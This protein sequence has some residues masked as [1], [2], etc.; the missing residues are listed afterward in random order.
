MLKTRR[1]VAAV[2]SVFV[3]TSPGW[4][5]IR[6]EVVVSGLS[7]PVAFIQDPAQSNVQFIVEQAG[8]IRVV[9]DGELLARDFLDLQ[10]QTT[11]SGEQGLLGLAFP[12]D[13]AVSRRFY[14][15]FTNTAGHTVVAR[16]LRSA[17]DPLVADPS[18]RF[19]LLWPDG[20]RFITQPF[21]NHNGGD[22]QFGSDGYLYIGMGDG[23][24][25]ND[26][27]H[28]A[29]DPATLL[30]KMLRLDVAVAD[31]DPEGFD[32][33]LDN[34]FRGG[35]SVADLIWS[36]GLRNPFRF[37]VDAIERGGTGALVIGDVGQN[38]WE[39]VNYEPFGRGGRNYGWR[40]RE[41][42]HDNVS[43]EPPAFLPLVDPIIE[44]S[45]AI[46]NVI[47]GGIVYRGTALGPAFGG[48][49]FYAD[50]GAGRLWSAFLNVDPLTSEATAA[51]II[52]HTAE[53]GGPSA[54]GN[55]SAF[56]ID[57]RREMY[58]VSYGF[59]Q[60]LRVLPSAGGSPASTCLTADPFVAI[61]GG[62]CVNGG[63]VPVGH[64]LVPGGATPPGTG[65][66]SG[67]S[68]G[69]SSCV[70]IMPAPDWVC[71]VDGWLP[72]DHPLVLAGGGAG[73]GSGAPSAGGADTGS[74]TIPDPFAAIGG[75][76]CIG[77]GWVPGNHPLAGAASPPASGGAS[78]GSGSASAACMIP[79]PFVA[80]GG[81]VC[82]NGGWVPRD[83]PLAA[84][85]GGGE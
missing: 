79:D 41:G 64:P 78:G 85:A 60:V 13:Y 46:G 17:S 59:G 23:G 11:A 43:A 80:I 27:F 19:D 82:V 84:G 9:R 29:Q 25:G 81:G 53:L 16:F 24:S 14:V 42:A 45:H 77:G 58:L 33:P 56:G 49:Y 44:Y 68:G 52:E 65:G 34:P 55:I 37:T 73:V 57:A 30:G 2:L 71:V 1:W 48:R 69:A 20:N 38:A 15:N 70:T 6:M 3:I 67:G 5:Q 26:P 62:V 21:G 39:E 8:R 18:S 66:S 50:F 10:G 31:S 28:N 47:T 74:C 63:W 54:V 36:F 61:G 83:H 76:A 7:L 40:N 32:P 75:G 35:G 22:L 72:P 12:P 51:A 4:T